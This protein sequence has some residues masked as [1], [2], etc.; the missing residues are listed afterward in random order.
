MEKRTKETNRPSQKGPRNKLGRVLINRDEQV[1]GC[2]MSALPPKADM[3]VAKTDVCF[4]PEADMCTA[5]TH[6]CFGLKTNISVSA[7]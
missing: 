2:S 6:A 7:H 1:G 5:L 3:C 4:G